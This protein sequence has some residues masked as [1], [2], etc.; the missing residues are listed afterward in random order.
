MCQ[1]SPICS[2]R[3]LQL[4][5]EEQGWW[6]CNAIHYYC[7]DLHI[8]FVSDPSKLLEIA[9]F[10]K[11]VLSLIPISYRLPYKYLK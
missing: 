7:I 9:V 2:I 3:I 1:K 6:G 10:L 8:M 4:F 5:C 11:Y